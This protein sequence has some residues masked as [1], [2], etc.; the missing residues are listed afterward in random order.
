[1]RKR[2][3][4]VCTGGV[5]AVAALLC[6]VQ[7]ASA[8]LISDFEEASLGAAG[9]T[10]DDT[11][12][13]SLVADPADASNQ[14]LS[15]VSG[16]SNSY[17]GLGASSVALNSTSTLF[18]RM[19]RSGDTNIGYGTSRVDDPFTWGSFAA[20]LV[21]NSNINSGIPS[22]SNLGDFA[23][24]TWYN[25]WLVLNNDAET[26]DVYAEGGAFATQTL[27]GSDF[28]FRDQAAAGDD[29]DTFPSLLSF[30]VRTTSGSGTLYLDDIYVTAGESLSNP[31]PEPSTLMLAL[32]LGLA[33]II[34]G[35][36]R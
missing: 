8:A 28:G 23:E 31:I 11:D 1:M 26:F 6:S 10:T 35:K 2:Q 14:V 15:V 25:A 3:C 20:Y 33:G 36:R 18:F 34:R 24:D 4:F 29:K 21:G 32:V 13:V 12:D 22:S 19:R 7:M 30:Y 17:V 5:L 27:L 9:W 16:S